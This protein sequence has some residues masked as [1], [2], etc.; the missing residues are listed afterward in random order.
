MYVLQAG[1]DPEVA[2]QALCQPEKRAPSVTPLPS[3]ASLPLRAFVDYKA[4]ERMMKFE[5]E[6]IMR[7]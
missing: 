4:F 3:H 1:I 5:A 6:V 2:L 7:A